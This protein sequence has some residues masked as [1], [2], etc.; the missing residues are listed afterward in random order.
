MRT[1]PRSLFF[2]AFLI[3][4]VASS[5]L[6]AC[7]AQSLDGGSRHAFFVRSALAPP[8]HPTD[9]GACRYT[10][11]PSATVLFEGRSD[12]GISDSYDLTLLAQDADATASTSITSAHVVLR[13]PSQELI[14]EFEAVTNGF[15][16]AGAVGI[17][18]VTVIDAPSRDLL[19]EHLPNRA[20][21]Q[22][23]VAD[24]TLRGR[25]AAGG[26]EVSTPVFSF[27]I[28]VC[29]GCLVDF[30]TGNDPT[31]PKQ[32]NCLR[33]AD[34]S[35]PRPCVT[36]QDEAVACQLCVGARPACD[37]LALAP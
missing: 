30:S 27:A 4:T 26:P 1:P 25:D 35:A 12:L 15:I 28:K 29:N 7:A 17:A 24:V 20:V 14:R 33:P 21:S 31:A 32:P 3:A 18:S 8:A 13:T 37:P 9:G 10:E 5:T 36:G 23:V 22:T 16:G 34:P 6:A 2:S 19:L 11:D